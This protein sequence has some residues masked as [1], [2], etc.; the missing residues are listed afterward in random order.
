MEEKAVKNLVERIG[1]V[2][3]GVQ[4]KRYHCYVGYVQSKMASQ[5][6]DAEWVAQ[7]Q[8][9]LPMIS[10]LTII[11]EERRADADEEE[12]HNGAGTVVSIDWNDV[13]L[14]ERTDLVIAPIAD[15]KMAKLFGIRVDDRDKEKD[16]TSVPAGANQNSNPQDDADILKH[17]M[18]MGADD[19]DDADD[20]ELVNLYDK[21]NPVIEVGKLWPNM[22]EFRMCFKT[23][24]MNHEFEAKTLWTGRK[25]FY[26]RSGFNTGIKC[27]HINNN[28]AESFKNKVKELKDLPVHDMVDQIRIMIM[29]MWDL[30][31]RIGELLQGD[32]L[33]AVV[34]HVVNMSRKL[35]HLVVKKSSFWG[36]EVRDTKT[37]K[38][39]VVNTDLHEC[40]CQEW[41]HTRKPCEHAILFLA[42]RPKL[43]MHPY[44]H[45]Y[46]SVQRFKD[47][48]ATQIPAL[49][50]QSQW[51]EVDFEFFM[52]PPI[53][54]RKAGRP[55]Q[56]RFKAWFER[57]GSSKKGKKDKDVK[58]KRAQEGNKNRCKL[59]EELGHRIGSPKC[60][61][62]PERPKRKRAEKMPP[63]VVEQCWS[64]KKARL[65]GCTKKR[66]FNPLT[67]PI[68]DAP[69]Q[70][71]HVLDAT[72][73]TE[74]VFDAPEQ[75]E[76]VSDAH[77]PILQTEP[78]LELVVQTELVVE[79]VVQTEPVLELVMQSEIVAE[80]EE[81][82]QVK[83]AEVLGR[84]VGRPTRRGEKTRSI[85]K[86]YVVEVENSKKSSG[87]KRQKK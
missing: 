41:Q 31:R 35:S 84:A 82:H 43:N 67:E 3:F 69:E 53:T 40:T 49:T 23:Y 58:T 66:R 80:V 70:T 24:A 83:Y 39:H 16:D 26:A 17:M 46:Y 19:V 57:G 14:E 55:K 65:N 52:C 1:R 72:E 6:A 59:C 33:P 7:K 30:R 50:D 4:I 63:L 37:S 12:G 18:E 9:L 47:A 85:N 71:E 28:L 64:V 87:K 56:S 61:Y 13:D 21:E 51:P 38:R 20:N 75:C 2:L 27:D 25:K 76:P 22:D 10:E 34:Q 36:S 8:M 79:L 48:Y 29:R 32:K 11:G 15:I 73:Q 42:S 62:T 86:L 74:P 77:E 54:G 78:V 60:R 44:L 68:L 45:D 81:V 5:M